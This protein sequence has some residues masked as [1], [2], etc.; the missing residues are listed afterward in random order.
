MFIQNQISPLDNH[1]NVIVDEIDRAS[2]LRF[3]VAYVREN[4][5]DIILDK[6]KDKP[7]KLLCSFDMG[8]TQLS[9][10]NKLLE[11]GIDVKVYE[12]NKGTF[13]PKIWLFGKDRQW[14]MLIGSAN[15]TRAAFT[16]NVEASVLMVDESVISDALVFFRYLWNHENSTTV[17]MDDISLRQ[18]KVKERMEFKA[19]IIDAKESAGDGKK[20]A[21]LFEYVKNWIDIPKKTKEASSTLWRGWYIIPDQG[22][23]DDSMIGNLCSYLPYI[24]GGITRSE[25]KYQKLL[26]KFMKN[27][28]FKEK[29]LRTLPRDLFVRQ[30]RNYLIKF[31]WCSYPIKE[32]GKFDKNVLHL[33]GLGEQ[34]LECKDIEC[35]KEL[36]TDRFFDYTFG[37]LSIAQFTADL[38]DRLG[39]INLLEF[40]YFVTHAYTYDDLET[41][42]NLVKIFRSLSK[43]NRKIFHKKYIAYFEQ[44]KGPT[45]TNVYGNYLKKNKHNIS[46][47]AWCKGFLRDKDFTLRLDNAN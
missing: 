45:A 29:N 28:N 12:S 36:Y 23:I 16:D 1:K 19:K 38:L 9:G 21:M 2:E 47:I 34:I 15:L 37:G 20:I 44:K 4:G 32:N 3:V 41:I 27:S 33:T 8:I 42:V 24:S 30:S 46:A 22:Y 14:K 11:N 40:S 13:H 10:I 26:E 39:Y 17:S 31:G 35:V 5:V 25:E 18:E 43:S 7:T 6:I